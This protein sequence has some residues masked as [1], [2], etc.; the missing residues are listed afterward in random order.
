MDQL[1]SRSVSDM[2]FQTAL[3][4][5]FSGL[6][7]LL[8]IVGIYG[9]VSYSV[10]RRTHEVGIR[11]ALGAQRRDVLRLLVGQEMA[12]TFAGAGVGGIAAFALAHLLS[13]FLYGVQPADPVTF[14]VAP[15]V[16]V[17]M[18]FLATFIPARRATKVDP[19]VALRYQ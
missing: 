15:L 3:L 17:A 11:M 18:A 8:A 4:T 2:R 19:T 5:I 14:V 16:L 12:L 9:V 7:L 1:L 10:S 6:A 13:G